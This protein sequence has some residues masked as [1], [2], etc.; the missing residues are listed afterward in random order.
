MAMKDHSCRQCRHYT[1][2][3]YAVDEGEELIIHCCKGKEIPEA[4]VE[5]G[6]GAL[7]EREDGSY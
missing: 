5:F 1:S 7:E 4:M 3:A 6:C 2:T